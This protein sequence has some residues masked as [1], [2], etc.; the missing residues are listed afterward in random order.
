MGE[1]P[2]FTR[3]RDIIDD[4]D[5]FQ[6]ALQRPLPK[7]LW[8]N[9]RR[10]SPAQLRSIL[11]VPMEPL[12]WWPS[13][14]RVPGTFTAGH[15]W[16][17]LAGL[18]N[19]QEEVSMLPP[20]A[21][22]LRPGERVLDLCAAPGNKTAQLGVGLGPEGTVIA[23]DRSVKRM[24]AASHTFERLGLLNVATTTLD[25]LRF[26]QPQR[27]FDKVLA[28][29]PCSAEGTCR[30]SSRRREV[31]AE[32]SE[33]LSRTQI[34]ILRRAAALCR[35]G[36]RIVYSTCTFAPEENELVI[37]TVL[38][39]SGGDL[40]LVSAHPANF[41]A[42][43]GL[44]RWGGR[45][46]DPSLRHALRV[47]PHQRD[48]GGFFVA[49]LERC[50][51]AAT[52]SGRG[53]P[54]G[55]LASQSTTVR[56]PGSRDADVR[57]P[58]ERTGADD[59]SPLPSPAAP[60]TSPPALVD[61]EERRSLLLPIE[62]RF[63]IDPEAFAPLRIFRPGRKS[64]YITSADHDPEAPA[65]ALGMRFI[66]TNSR[67][68]MTTAAAIRFGDLATVNV[69]ELSADQLRAYLRR[70]DQPLTEAQA[71]ACSGAGSV[72]LR[73]R[74]FSIGLGLYHPASNTLESHYPKAWA[75]ASATV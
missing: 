61:A 27:L 66:H 72:I 8:T 17:Y 54:R 42:S 73:Y 1:R 56:G 74:G 18:F 10:L 53:A 21:L 60:R 2:A 67:P 47:W 50:G 36:G 65:D 51:D 41:H 4:W 58:T 63:G 19:I 33:K 12:P 11:G 5:A 6:A 64:V 75:R 7:T 57:P 16:A 40:R 38:R 34:G 3:Y 22:D 13:A 39:E 29:V 24:R 43:T 35:V 37:D 9:T 70:D 52:G 49:V 25:A 45:E 59:R 26:P 20:R 68:T 44:T 48:T 55:R 30:K 46:L 32:E 69:I 14:F 28:D 62:E 23:N 15:H 71:S 31:Q